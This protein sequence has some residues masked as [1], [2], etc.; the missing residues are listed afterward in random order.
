MAAILENSGITAGI[1]LR[2]GND[3]VDDNHADKRTR[4]AQQSHTAPA[5][6]SSSS[7]FSYF[8]HFRE[9]LYKDAKDAKKTRKIEQTLGDAALLLEYAVQNSPRIEP[10]LIAEMNACL[11]EARKA[12]YREYMIDGAYRDADSAYHEDPAKQEKFLLTFDKLSKLMAPITADSIRSSRYEQSNRVGWLPRYLLLAAIIFMVFLYLQFSWSVGNRYLSEVHEAFATKTTK[13]REW[14][15]LRADVERLERSLGMD[16]DGDTNGQKEE[17]ADEVKQRRAT[18]DKAL[19]EYVY[20]DN[21]LRSRL[22]MLAVW[23]EHHVCQDAEFGFMDCAL[24]MLGMKPRHHDGLNEHAGENVLGTSFYNRDMIASDMIG[25]VTPMVERLNTHVI[26]A[27]LGLLG[28]LVFVIRQLSEQI[29][30]RTLVRHFASDTLARICLGMIGGVVGGLLFADSDKETALSAI[31]PIALP[32]FFGYAVEV[33]FTFLDR[34]VK[35]FSPDAAAT[36]A[37]AKTQ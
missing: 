9:W 20:A 37:T 8:S 13:E 27:V 23:R 12:G 36:S 28:S 2:A 29:K 16:I 10:P 30:A 1:A 22:P 11:T 32:F 18:R 21:T 24:H 25:I 15:G 5:S 3:D 35:T 26:P 7:Y 4:A 34:I 19:S 33:V 17:M 31:P 14:L 6:P